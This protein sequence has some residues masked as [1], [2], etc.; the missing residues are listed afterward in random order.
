SSTGGTGILVQILNKYTPIPLGI[1][2]ALIDGF[3]VGIGVLAFDFDTVMYSIIALICITYVI[4]LMMA[5][6]DSSRNLMIISQE[7]QAIKEY[8][9]KVADRGVT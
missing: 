9:T 7:H 8:I 3:V 6:S 1:L 2:M 4:N 5:G